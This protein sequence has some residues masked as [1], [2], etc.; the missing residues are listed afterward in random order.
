MKDLSPQAAAA[1][2]AKVI[3]SDDEIVFV[4][5]MYASTMAR[6]SWS[7]A[8]WDIYDTATMYAS[9]EISNVN[10]ARWHLF[11]HRFPDYEKQFSR[12][13]LDDWERSIFTQREAMIFKIITVFGFLQYEILILLLL[14]MERV[15]SKNEAQ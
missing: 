2:M 10:D 6:T 5:E 3:C 8:E 4:V 7:D 12:C 14:E 15:E 9:D 1:L 11:T 13:P